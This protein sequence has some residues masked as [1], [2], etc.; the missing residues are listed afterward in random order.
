MANITS[1]NKYKMSHCQTG[2]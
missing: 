1:I 2:Q